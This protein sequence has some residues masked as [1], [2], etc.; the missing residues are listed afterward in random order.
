M[1]IPLPGEVRGPGLKKARPLSRHFVSAIGHLCSSI[2]VRFV[3]AQLGC[4]L[5]LWPEWFGLRKVTSAGTTATSA[6]L[7]KQHGQLQASSLA[8]HALRPQVD[9][10]ACGRL[11]WRHKASGTQCWV[12]AFGSQRYCLSRRQSNPSRCSR[13]LGKILHAAVCGLFAFTIAS[14]AR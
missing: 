1:L 3:E 8:V 10:H 4:D 6:A 13:R 14:P 5:G 7:W 12:G 9:S 2:V 11:D